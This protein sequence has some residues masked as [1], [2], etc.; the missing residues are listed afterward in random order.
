MAL[1]I[2]NDLRARGAVNCVVPDNGLGICPSLLNFPKSI[3]QILQQLRNFW[4]F[5]LISV[6]IK[7]LW[8]VYSTFPYIKM[9]LLH[10]SVF[11]NVV[12]LVSMVGWD[13]ITQYN[14][15]QR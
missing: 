13:E 4:L 14:M 11:C 9:E 5:T 12:S 8:V 3:V 6:P 10:L 1:N 2:Y 15:G 7:N